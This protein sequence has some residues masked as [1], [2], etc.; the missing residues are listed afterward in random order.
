MLMHKLKK[1]AKQTGI[2]EIAIA[3]G[4]SANSGL[5]QALKKEAEASGWNH[6][7]PDFQYCRDN[8]GMIGIAAYYKYQKGEFVGQELAAEARMEFWLIIT[9]I[10]LL[11]ARLLDFSIARL[12]DFLITR[13]WINRLLD[14]WTS[15]I[16]DY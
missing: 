15:G 10:R 11:D 9:T 14:F 5:R 3:G 8:A 1:A 12:L 13:Y 4:V 6:Y 2:A 7:I 16:L